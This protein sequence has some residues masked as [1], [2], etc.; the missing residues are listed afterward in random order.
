MQLRTT[1]MTK[2]EMC[3]AFYQ[4]LSEKEGWETENYKLFLIKGGFILHS[5][6]DKK[7][8]KLEHSVIEKLL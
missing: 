2:Q 1:N 6:K 7:E 5:K 3:H 4:E 8:V